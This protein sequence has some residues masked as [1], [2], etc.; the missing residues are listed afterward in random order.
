MKNPLPPTN[1]IHNNIVLGYKRKSC[2]TQ[3]NRTTTNNFKMTSKGRLLLAWKHW[4]WTSTNETSFNIPIPTSPHLRR[5][6]EVPTNTVNI[7]LTLVF[8]Y[9]LY[10][11]C[12][13]LLAQNL[14]QR[15]SSSVTPITTTTTA[16]RPR[17]ESA[18]A[19]PY[20]ASTSNSIQ[21]STSFTS[22]AP[23]PIVPPRRASEVRDLRPRPTKD[24]PDLISFTAPPTTSQTF[25]DGF[26]I[27]NPTTQID[28]AHAK[29]QRMVSDIHRLNA[30]YQPQTH[31]NPYGFQTPNQHFHNQQHG[32][33]GVPSMQLVPYP[34]QQTEPN[35]PVPLTVDQL[36]KLYSMNYGV[37]SMNRGMQ[38]PPGYIRH[39]QPIHQQLHQ[40]TQP[41]GWVAQTPSYSYA[42]AAMPPPAQSTISGFQQVSGIVVGV[43]EPSG[44][45]TSSQDTTSQFDFNV[46]LQQP[47]VSLGIL[48]AF[49]ASELIAKYCDFNDSSLEFENSSTWQILNIP[50]IFL[51]ST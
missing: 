19:L 14:M 50:P 10:N 37:Q 18:N 45:T 5:S 29:F 3:T 31:P 23:P 1:N 12:F 51:I 41:F 39:Q 9:K 20:A 42:A 36:N 11:I 2:R 22:I 38:Q 21:N 35:T 25:E 8:K 27:S 13:D 17:P 43:A 26:S 4:P 6:Q 47:K 30:Q 32:A 49:D 33:V 7:V 46:G 40:S 28:A 24:E 48:H 16:L 44:R 34:K 15:Q